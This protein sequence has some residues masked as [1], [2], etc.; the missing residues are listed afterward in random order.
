MWW[1]VQ[2]SQEQKALLKK[3]VQEGK[4]KRA[5]GLWKEAVKLAKE[6]IRER[7]EDGGYVL[8]CHPVGL[9][10]IYFVQVSATERRRGA[11]KAS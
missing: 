10:S 8:K 6:K 1:G 5:V 11:E 3:A 2:D 7:A 4:W 9:W